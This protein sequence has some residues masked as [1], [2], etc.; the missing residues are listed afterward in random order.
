MALTHIPLERIDQNQLQALLLDGKAAE[1]LTIEYKRDTYGGNDDAKAEFLADISSLANSR[2]G[3]LL[4]GIEAP[5]GVPTSFAAFTGDPDKERLRLEQMARSGLEPRI[6]NLQT[7][8]VRVASGGWV[9]IVRVPRSYSAPHRVVFRGRNRFWAR[10]SAGKYEPNVDELRAMFVFAPQLA[11][12]MR[13]FRLDRVARIAAG[14]APVPLRDDCC[15]IL[16]VIPFSHFDLRPAVSL[17]ALIQNK[18]RL[19]PIGTPADATRLNFDGLLAISYPENGTSQSYV[20][21]FRGGA[22]EAVCSSITGFV[23]SIDIRRVEH[24]IVER[25]LEYAR[26]L[27][28]CG[29]G[30]PLAVMASVIGVKGR[31]LTVAGRYEPAQ[32]EI[33]DRDQLHLP[34]V[35]LDEMPADIL[36]FAQT[37][38]PTLDQLANAV[39]IPASLNFDEKGDYIP[40]R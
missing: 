13:D 14:D 25:S 26:A 34:E 36:S 35:V 16:H 17:R 4:I 31:R 37:L 29:A 38:R 18:T 32:G 20:Q 2:G 24:Y 19:D 1:A 21:A 28:E 9:L 40:Q 33:A 30:P 10:S 8:A 27:D 6:S 11:E 23:G 7:K 22:I 3:D 5:A 39:G 12:R 15:L